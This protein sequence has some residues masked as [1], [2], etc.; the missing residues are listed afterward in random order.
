MGKHL[1]RNIRMTRER[2]RL[3]E[4]ANTRGYESADKMLHDMYVVQRIPVHKIAEQLFTPMWT[5]RKRFD[6][7]GIKIRTRGGPNNVKVDITPELLGEISRDG[8]PAVSERLGIDMSTLYARLK[9]YK[10]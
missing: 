3:E 9:D 4:V 1:P 5:L 6:E 8:I 2:K 7:L 10:P